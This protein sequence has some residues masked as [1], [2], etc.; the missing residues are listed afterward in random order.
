MVRLNGEVE[1]DRP[2]AE[3][4]AHCKGH[5]A[6]SIDVYYIGGLDADGNKPKDTRTVE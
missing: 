2:I 1:R 4:G 5:N 6:T 3:V